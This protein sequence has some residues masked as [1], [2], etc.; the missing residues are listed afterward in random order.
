VAVSVESWAQVIC[1]RELNQIVDLHDDGSEPSMYD[2]RVGPRAAPVIAIECVRAMDPTLTELWKGGP[3]RGAMSLRVAGDWTVGLT[4]DA[5]LKHL[6]RLETPLQKCERIGM[7]NVHVDWRLK[8]FQPNLFAELERL[9]IAWADC[10]R[11][12]G[13]G[14]VFLTL[15]SIGGMVDEEGRAVPGWIESFLRAEE[16]S[17]VLRKLAQSNAAQCH[18]IVPVGW[19]GAPWSVESYLTD[20]LTVLP[21]EKPHLPDPVTSVWIVSMHATHGIR[22]D[23]MEWH[24]FD[25][26][27]NSVAA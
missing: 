12:Q 11:P 16:Q 19:G 3:Q 27:S 15:E 5:R 13:G 14:K 7:L 23:G 2:L 24:T 10:F 18:V 8:R 17:D 25:A 20:G 26:R 22:W 4:R 21:T 9:A 6:S 1:Q